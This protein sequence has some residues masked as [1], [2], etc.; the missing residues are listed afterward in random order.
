MVM[1]SMA[2]ATKVFSEQ[3]TLGILFFLPLRS[4][5]IWSW[6]FGNNFCLYCMTTATPIVYLALQSKANK[7][8]WQK[9]YFLQSVNKRIQKWKIM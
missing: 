7:E 5:L 3:L 6:L 1:V 9:F 4:P 2:I 8:N